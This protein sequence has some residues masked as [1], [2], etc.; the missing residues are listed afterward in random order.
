MIYLESPPLSKTLKP[1]NPETSVHTRVTYTSQNYTL[2]DI[3]PEMSPH[4]TIHRFIKAIGQNGCK[5]IIVNYANTH[6]VGP[7]GNLEATEISTE[8]RRS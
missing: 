5:R 4:Q 6:M 2:N 3:K 7:T 1:R 8:N